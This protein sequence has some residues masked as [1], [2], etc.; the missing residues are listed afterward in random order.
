MGYSG[1]SVHRIY[2][3]PP[4]STGARFSP[5]F[6]LP[7]QGTCEK[8]EDRVAG[9]KCGNQQKQDPAQLPQAYF[10][11]VFPYSF[12]HLSSPAFLFRRHL[13]FPV[14]IPF[15]R[16]L[17]L[18]SVLSVSPLSQALCKTR[19]RRKITMPFTTAAAAH[20]IQIQI[21]EPVVKKMLHHVHALMRVV[22][23]HQI[24]LPK[25]LKGVQ[26]GKGR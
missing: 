25:Y 19:I 14:Y 24:R 4:D 7:H 13:L 6:I 16:Y 5:Q 1:N 3:G 20:L 8:E 22:P 17:H 18:F 12:F 11:N 23:R 10:S 26:Q 15:F 9:D 21:P 2:P